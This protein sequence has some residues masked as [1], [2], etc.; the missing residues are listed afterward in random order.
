[1]WIVGVV[2]LL[3]TGAGLIAVIGRVPRVRTG[4]DAWDLPGVSGI[5]SGLVY[6]LAGF[7]VASATFLA[8]V[9]SARD[10]PAF[11]TVIG[12][13]LLSFLILM[14]ASMMYGATPTR[15]PPAEEPGQVV[16]ALWSVL[17][18]G[19]TSSGWPST[20]SPSIR[21]CK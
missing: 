8:G 11:A 4:P 18:N 15:L 5:Y 2:L 12:L 1:M 10:S 19:S 3:L 21:C 7:S 6:T 9:S 13:L 16:L 14:A 20:G 17:A